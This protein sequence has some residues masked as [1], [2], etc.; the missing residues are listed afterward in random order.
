MT[1]GG[2]TATLNPAGL[3][4]HMSLRPHSCPCDFPRTQETQ[5]HALGHSSVGL[6]NQANGP[7]WDGHVVTFCSPFP[8]PHLGWETPSTHR[9]VSEHPENN[10]WDDQTG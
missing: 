4:K 5:S 7:G 10:G 6:S 3:R 8:S 1:S 9:W 2:H